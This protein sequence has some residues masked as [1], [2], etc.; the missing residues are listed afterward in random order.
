[1]IQARAR[2]FYGRQ[3]QLCKKSDMKQKIDLEIIIQTSYHPVQ[4][5]QILK[6]WF[7]FCK[8]ISSNVKSSY[9]SFMIM[10]SRQDGV[11]FSCTRHSVECLDG[12][13]TLFVKKHAVCHAAHHRV[14]MQK[15][16]DKSYRSCR[17]YL[18]CMWAFYC[19]MVYSYK[20]VL[21]R[22][23]RLLSCIYLKLR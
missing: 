13:I 23:I 14:F 1:M 6:T 2:T 18:F 4:N 11:G 16:S 21:L 10:P 19:S 15:F 5:L 7:N 20:T 17:K 22:T 3:F 8:L 9:V 12:E